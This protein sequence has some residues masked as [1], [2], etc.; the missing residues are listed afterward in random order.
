MSVDPWPMIKDILTCLVGC[1]ADNVV[2][3]N[4]LG[5]NLTNLSQK[6]ETL[7]QHYGDVEREIGR[8]GGRELKD[9]N[10]VEGWQ[11]RVR[12]KAEAVKKILE[13]GNKETQQKCLGGHC[14]KNFCSS[15]K[16]GLTVLEEITK[17][18]NLTEEKKDF[19]LDFVEPQISPV[20]EIVEMQTFGLDLPFKEVCEYIES[21]SVGMVG[22]YGMGG[23][24]K[25]ALLKTIQKKFLEKN[26]FNLMFRIKLA[27]DT[28]FSENQILENVQNKIRDTLN[29]HEDVWTNKSKKSRANLIRAELKSKTFLLLIDN[30]GP[31]LDL[32]EAGVPEL[33]KSPGS[34]LVFTARSKDSLAKMKKVCRGIKPIEMKCL[35]LESALDL[36]KCSSDNVSNANEEIKRLA[37]DVAEECKGLPLALITVG[38]VMASKKNADEWRHAI[39]Q[40][41]SYPSQFPGMAGDVFPKLKFSYD[42]LSGDVYRKCFLY[43]SLFPEEQKIRKRELVNL[44]IGESFIQKFADI[45]QARYKGADIIGN[46]ERA[47]LLESGVSDDCVEMHD[48]IRDMALWLSCEEGKNEENVLVSQNADVIPALD[49][50]KWANAER[51]SLWGPTFEN[52]SEIRS[53]RCKTLIIRETNLKELPGE[54][55]QKS[56]QVLDLSHNEDLTKLPVEV[57]KLINLRHLDLSFTG[58]NALPLEVRELKNLKT[59]LV[60]GTEMLIP[61]VVI[62]QLLSLQIFSKDIR[63]PSNEKTLLEGLDCLKRLICLGIILTKYESI[64]YLLNSTKL[65]SCINNLTLADCSDLHQLNISSSSMIRMRT[66]EMLDIRSCSLEELKILPDDK[67]LYGCFKELSRV[68]IRKCP[69]KNLTWLIYARML[70]TLELDDCNSV[71]EIIADDIVE[72]E[73]ETCQKIFSQLKRLDLSYLSSL[74]TI[75]RQA[76]SFPSL[77]KITVY[78]CPRL[79]KLPFNSDSARTS[80]KEIRGKENWWNG[81]QWDEEVK[82]IFS[83]RFVK[84]AY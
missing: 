67:G 79:R 51:I 55:F 20:D 26:S 84:L 77:E 19:D 17:I 54:F 45:F 81:L 1:T 18:E 6:L 8:A 53:S 69:I 83:S 37:K 59:L 62:S 14:P 4:D 23:V 76:L 39:T 42:S 3:I 71:V 22:I 35:K 80:L 70:Q 36:L 43:C 5:D 50:E 7:M 2:V 40:L 24:G 11:K 60:D 61:K 47:Y 73:D 21:H 34:K 78:E 31:K 74:H 64:E 46:L 16:L 68:V 13:K 58:I 15:Y 82:K 10:R 27:R 65:Q 25:T 72:T 66:L 28:S 63:H 44:W 29:I 49:L 32:S 41:Q 33:D 38:K 52:L 9:K 75:C 56:L 57:G 12:E 48:V 30:V